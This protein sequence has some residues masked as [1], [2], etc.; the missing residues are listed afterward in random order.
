MSSTKIKVFKSLAA[1]AEKCTVCP[2]LADKKAVLSNLNGNISPKV[3]FVAEAPGRQGADR[4]RRP[5]WGDKSG[6]NFQVLLDSIDLKRE[7]IFIT[8]AV[9]CSP[10]KPNGANRRPK[11]S[12]I[13]N[14]SSF[15]K[16]TIDLIDPPVVATLGTVALG[17]LDS[18]E[19]HGLKIKDAV[20][21]PVA[22]YGRILV[23]FYHPSPQVI[24]AIRKLDQQVA[25][26]ADLGKLIE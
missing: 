16:R 24:A 13:R 6:E 4:T 10:R 17:A 23:P 25:D 26:Y 15:L 18:L 9:M 12:E 8:N 19:E 11:M 3:L 21:K 7:E 22:W 20:A 2:D 1:E 5:F 14:C